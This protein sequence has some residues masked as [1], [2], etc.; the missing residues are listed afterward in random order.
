MLV[1]TYEGEHNHLHGPSHSSVA[2]DHQS[3]APTKPKRQQEL[4]SPEPQRSKW[5][6]RCPGFKAALAAVISRRMFRFGDHEELV[7]D[8]A[9]WTTESCFLMLG[10]VMKSWLGLL[11][12][13]D[14]SGYSLAS[15]DT[16]VEFPAFR[17]LLPSVVPDDDQRCSPASSVYTLVIR[18]AYSK[19]LKTPPFFGG[20][21]SPPMEVVIASS[22]VDAGI[23]CWDLRSGSE[24]LRY[25]SCSSAPHGL[26]SVAGR[27]L[28]SSQLRDS[29][30]S[31]SSPIFFWSWDKVSPNP[32]LSSTSP[33]HA[34][35][36]TCGG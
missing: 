27:F 6:W 28:A 5:M 21:S 24:Q 22:P 17:I 3:P 30:S 33:L 25:R 31:A 19:T 12:L 29:P 4:E 32:N 34:L 13:L 16:F 11:L 35:F 14:F 7:I 18:N 10:N 9:R 20:A 8:S 23:G 1:A 2:C 36:H 26:L 15:A